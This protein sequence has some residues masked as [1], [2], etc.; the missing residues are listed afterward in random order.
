[1]LGVGLEVFVA[2]A[3]LEEVKHGVAVALGGEARG[4]GAIHLREAAFGEL[5][6]RVDARESVL[7]R[8]AEEVG[9]VDFEAASGFGVSEESGGGVVED[10]RGFEGGTGN[11]VLDARDF[12]AE[13]ET[14]G[15]GLGRVKKTPHA[16]AKVGGLGE[17]GC[18]FGARAAEGEDAR[19]CGYRAEDFVGPLRCKV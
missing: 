5:V 12:F 2:A 14:L 1:M 10:E 9:R 15:L 18:V 7:H 11:A 6:R 19:S 4:E 3:Q 17:V 13:V 16:S 8:H